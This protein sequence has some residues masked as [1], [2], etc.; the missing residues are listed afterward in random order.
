MSAAK[1]IAITNNKGGVGKTT[2]AI[3][4]AALFA[5][6]GLKV[7]LIDNDPQGN[8]GVYLGQNISE[9][10]RNLADVYAGFSMKKIGV[11]IPF[12]QHLKPYNVTF[13]QDH[14]TVFL[15]N[16]RL[17]FVAE[18]F[19]K[20]AALSEFL[21]EIKPEFD[22]IVIDN[23]PYIGYLTRAALLS[24]DLVLIPTEAGIGSLS[25]I[26]QIIKEAET[27]NQRYWRKITVRVFVNNFQHTEHFDVNNLRK[28]KTMLGNRL[29]N[30]YVP[31]NQHIR[32]SKELGLPIHILERVAKISSRG[33]MAYRIL[34]KNILKD[35]LPELFTNELPTKLSKIADSYEPTF[36]AAPPKKPVA[37]GAKPIQ[38]LAP[39]GVTQALAPG[40]P[41]HPLHPVPPSSSPA[42]PPAGLSPNPP[43]SRPLPGPNPNIPHIKIDDIAPDDEDE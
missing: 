30:T 36:P 8:V 4:I 24:A 14:L 16:H 25:G 12:N 18:D 38:P 20:I 7:A 26:A 13:R 29:Y 10:K 22:L 33:A 35:V 41:A 9:N 32:K 37:P 3:S 34:A 2:T 27:L 39:F 42:T 43:A 1:V 11:T 28:L 23:G 21:N 31:A 40:T 19:Q 15:S 17:A 6:W 5:D